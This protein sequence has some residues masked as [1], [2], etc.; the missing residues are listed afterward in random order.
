MKQYL[1]T[2][3][4][5][6]RK[7]LTVEWRSR[8]L[9][10]SMLVLALVILFIFNF[11]LELD[12]QAR[13]S[14]TAGA[15]W[16]TFAFSGTLGLNRALALEQENGCL[17]GLLL[18]PVDR[19]AIFFGKLLASLVM[20][21]LVAAIVLPLFSLFFNT[22]LFLPGLLLV[23]LLG[24]LGYSA[25]GVLLAGMAV[26]ARTR[27]ILLPILLFP[28]V[29]PVLVAAVRASSGFLASLPFTDVRF[30]L[31]LLL[32]FD[33][34]YLTVGWMAFNYVIED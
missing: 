4:T 25:V 16:I 11:T 31:D 10:S 29:L 13:S 21:L 5:I 14:V 19:S 8:E 20:M 28:V 6:T 32:V 30:Y 26:R 34:V 27:D 24:S 22:S 9:L 2:L 33:A 1:F 23:I 3:F 17:D 7:D 15:L 18:A 12:I